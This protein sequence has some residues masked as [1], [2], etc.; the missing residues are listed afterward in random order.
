MQEIDMLIRLEQRS[1][2]P[3]LSA[4]CG[5]VSGRVDVDNTPVPNIIR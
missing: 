1:E 4:E 5:G 2:K 3:R